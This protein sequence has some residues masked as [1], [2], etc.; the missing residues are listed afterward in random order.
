MENPRAGRHTS[1]ICAEEKKRKM[2]ALVSFFHRVAMEP[3]HRE[4]PW[5]QLQER[6]AAGAASASQSRC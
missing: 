1:W 5:F 3:G 6:S 4:A 2:C